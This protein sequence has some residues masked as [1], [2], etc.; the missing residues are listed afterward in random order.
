M[1]KK[2]NWFMGCGIGCVVVLAV[3]ILGGV[4]L[5]TTGKRVVERFKEVGESQRVLTERFGRIDD[6]TPAADGRLAPDRIEAFL[7]VQETL[8]PTATELAGHGRAL[9]DLEEHDS[10][11]LGAVVTGFRSMLGIGRAA[12]AYLDE[13]NR[14]LLEEGMGLGEFTYLYL[15]CYH[16]WLGNSFD[17]DFG[18]VMHEDDGGEA[19]SSDLR[20]LFL[21]WLKAQRV[22]AVETGE[23]PAWLGTLDG[24]I[25]ALRIAD[26]RVPWA[27]GLPARIAAGLEPYRERIEATYVPLDPLVGVG[28][29]DEEGGFD[30]TI[31]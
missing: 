29:D 7:R 5:F 20:R 28:S 27:D 25:E 23:N 31:E 4:G 2:S 10:K 24:E 3:T 13:R 19:R 14:S 18:D 22:A 11:S 21:G 26:L 17:P 9:K 30:F 12:A 1:A 6:F 8:L 16:A 15:V